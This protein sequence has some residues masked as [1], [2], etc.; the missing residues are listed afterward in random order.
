MKKELLIASFAL[1]GLVSAQCN[2]KCSYDAPPDG[3]ITHIEG[4]N[5]NITEVFESSANNYKDIFNRVKTKHCSLRHC[6]ILIAN[7][8]TICWNHSKKTRRKIKK[9]LKKNNNWF[10]QYLLERPEGSP[11]KPDNTN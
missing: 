1:S 2:M 10:D 11:F 7:N 4:F 6:L 9:Q 3:T 5:E 8:D